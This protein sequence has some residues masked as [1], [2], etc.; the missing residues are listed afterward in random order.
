VT[1]VVDPAV[2]RAKF[3]AEVGRFNSHH[4][5]YTKR[6]WWMMRAEF[7]IVEIAFLA[8]KIRPPV[9]TLTARFDFTDF[10]LKPLSVKFIDPFTG[11]EVTAEQL[12]SRMKRLDPSIPPEVGAAMLQHGQMPPH[13]E[14]IQAYPG[15][16]GFLCLPGVREYHE[17]SAHS[18]DPWELHRDTG[19]GSMLQIADKIWQYGSD[20]FDRVNIELR[21]SYQQSLL[22]A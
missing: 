17:H 8:T 18:G 22:P 20:P 16:P 10:D 13:Q 7:P 21:Q 15:Q 11:L 6:G 2:S 9:V 3:E 1:Q 12:H 4:S 19:E 14:L 5:S